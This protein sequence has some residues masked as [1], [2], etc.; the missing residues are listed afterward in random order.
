[1][2]AGEGFRLRVA[3]VAAAVGPAALHRRASTI[4]DVR[5]HDRGG[6]LRIESRPQ[7]LLELPSCDGNFTRVTAEG[8]N[9]A[10]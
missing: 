3:G 9:E 2:T 5:S 1:M 7:Y 10:M 8:S 4:G 6:F